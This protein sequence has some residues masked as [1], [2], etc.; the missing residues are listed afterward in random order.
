MERYEHLMAKRHKEGLSDDEADELGRLMAERRGAEYANAANPPEDVEVERDARVQSEEELDAQREE[1]AG[2]E[3]GASTARPPK[4]TELQP[5][6][7][8]EERSPEG[9]DAGTQGPPHA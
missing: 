7:D 4:G 9:T 8:E 5:D 1:E 6:E 2:G 3:E